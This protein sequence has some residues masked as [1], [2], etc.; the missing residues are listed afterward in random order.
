LNQCFNEYCKIVYE[1]NDYNIEL[2]NSKLEEYQS[3]ITVWNAVFI[4][5]YEV[6][7]YYLNISEDVVYTQNTIDTV[8]TQKTFQ[9]YIENNCYFTEEEYCEKNYYEKDEIKYNAD[10]RMKTL[11][12]HIIYV[13]RLHILKVCGKQTIVSEDEKKLMDMSLNI[14]AFFEYIGILGLTMEDIDIEYYSEIV[15]NPSFYE[16]SALTK[17]KKYL[18]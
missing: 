13:L 10:V 18:L 12:N 7:R 2:F 5:V 9:T 3:D 6:L 16:R 14:V 17:I 8:Y 4:S 1:K 15:D 11:K